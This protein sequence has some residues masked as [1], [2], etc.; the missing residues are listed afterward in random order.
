M[1][2]SERDNTWDGRYSRIKN[3]QD[4]E[5]DQDVLTLHWAKENKEGLLKALTKTS[6]E[7]QKAINNLCDTQKQNLTGQY[8]T[9]KGNIEN[10]KTN[11]EQL[12]EE[13]KTTSKTEK[14]TLINTGDIKKSEIEHVENTTGSGLTYKSERNFK[15]TNG[16]KTILTAVVII[17]KVG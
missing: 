11:I 7:Q 9:Y 17:R 4:P 10:I 6:E 3:I 12:Y 1:A 15:S 5:E 8:Q 2:R 14:E 13:I 16:I